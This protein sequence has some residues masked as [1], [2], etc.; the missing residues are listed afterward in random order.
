MRLYQPDDAAPGHAVAQIPH[1]RRDPGD[2]PPSSPR[3]AGPGSNAGGFPQSLRDAAPTDPRKI[4]VRGER[5]VAQS[6]Q[7]EVQVPR[8]A[9]GTGGKFR[10][11]GLAPVGPEAEA[12]AES[13]HEV[14][15]FRR[16]Q[17]SDLVRI[18]SARQ[19]HLPS[20]V[21]SVARD[22]PAPESAAAFVVAS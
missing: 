4:A 14:I 3:S 16:G 15:D 2:R 21:G 12:L 22:L 13:P 17:A 19:S 20:A 8:P 7:R 10:E 6:L 1:N 9:F 5:L 11:I 18:Q